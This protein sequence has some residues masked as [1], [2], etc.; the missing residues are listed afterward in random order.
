MGSSL[1]AGIFLLSANMHPLSL[2]YSRLQANL[3]FG[4]HLFLALLLLLVRR[5]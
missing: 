5:S 2:A 4:L 1:Y 3:L